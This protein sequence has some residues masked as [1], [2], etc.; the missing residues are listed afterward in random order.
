[1][2]IETLRIFCDVVDHKSFSRGATMHQVSQ[3]AA[4]QSVHRLEKLFGVKLIDRNRR[5]LVLTPEGR[6][7]Y[8]AFRDVLQSYDGIGTRLQLLRKEITGLVRVAA[9]YSVGLHEMGRA[10]QEFMLSYPKAKIRLEYLRSN[11]IYEAVLRSQADLGILSYPV[12]TPDLAV[13]PLR[14]EPM[15]VVCPKSHRFASRTELL[16]EELSSEDFVSFDRDLPIRK[17]IDR[18]FRQI[19]ITVRNVMEFDNIETVKEAVVIGSGVAILPEQTVRQSARTG[20]LA[21]IPIHN[22]P[23]QRP[24]GIIYRQREVLTPAAVKFIETLQNRQDQ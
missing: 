4:T 22:T 18:Y 11:K 14:S 17:A 6:I 19:G 24:L 5:P 10:M 7:C 16:A 21:A 20:E 23:L 2:N 8:E 3:S 1:M 15:V 9:I 12:A 13:V